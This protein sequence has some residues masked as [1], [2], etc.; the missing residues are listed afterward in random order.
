MLIKVSNTGE[1]TGDYWANL[2]A[3]EI[4]ASNQPICQRDQRQRE[5]YNYTLS[6]FPSKRKEIPRNIKVKTGI[7]IWKEENIQ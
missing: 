2:M 7:R 3:A 1:V 6:Q 4:K 5:I